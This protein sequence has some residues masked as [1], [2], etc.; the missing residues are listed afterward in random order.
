[1]FSNFR[2]RYQRVATSWQ[3]R[4]SAAQTRDNGWWHAA[5][6]VGGPRGRREGTVCRSWRGFP[7]KSPYAI[8]GQKA[9]RARAG[10]VLAEP[11]VPLA[12][13]AFAVR[14]RLRPG[15]RRSVH[16]HHLRTYPAYLSAPAAA[17]SLIF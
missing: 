16:R 8:V 1:M 9:C 13:T 2:G 11:D 7:A 17:V 5:I 12:E 14:R 4:Q 3:P 6:K 15:S 10:P